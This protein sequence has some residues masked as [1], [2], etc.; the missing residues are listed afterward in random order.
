VVAGFEGDK[1]AFER[2]YWDQ[3]SLLAQVGALDKGTLPVTGAEQAA[4]F[5]DPG[6]PS[7]ELIAKGT[8]VR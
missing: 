2:I 4:R 5:L 1:I 7:N 8:N 3:A 6:L